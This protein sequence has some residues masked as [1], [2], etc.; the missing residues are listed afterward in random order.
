M[1]TPAQN[2]NMSLANYCAIKQSTQNGKFNINAYCKAQSRINTLTQKNINNTNMQF[3]T[4]FNNTSIS[5][6]MRYS[7]LIRNAS[8]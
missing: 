2:I 7:Q 5:R 4:A 3:N 1:S 8:P 6:A